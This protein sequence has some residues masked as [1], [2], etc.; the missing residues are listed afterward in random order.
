[1]KIAE[2]KRRRA[3][4]LSIHVFNRSRAKDRVDWPMQPVACREA[5]SFP[6]RKIV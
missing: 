6:Y 4:R 1:M 3:L 5:V 2:K